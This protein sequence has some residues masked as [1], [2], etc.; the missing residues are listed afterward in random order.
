MTVFDT[1]VVTQLRTWPARRNWNATGRAAISAARG[2][3]TRSA[4]R[5]GNTG[6]VML[7][8]GGVAE[9]H[10]SAIH[11]KEVRIGVDVT[12]LAVVEVIEQQVSNCGRLVWVL[13]LLLAVR[14]GHCSDLATGG[15]GRP[16][17]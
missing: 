2:S 6:I 7:L 3:R 11:S 15:L 9:Y 8:R 10:V 17:F 14:S 13:R 1:T 4:A 5:D 12:V 16:R